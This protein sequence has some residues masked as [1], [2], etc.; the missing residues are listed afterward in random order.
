[1]SVNVLGG[2]IASPQATGIRLRVAVSGCSVYHVYRVNSRRLH[3]IWT[4]ES[5][6]TDNGGGDSN[7]DD[8]RLL[9]DDEQGAVIKEPNITCYYPNITCSVAMNGEGYSPCDSVING[10]FPLVVLLGSRVDP[11]HDNIEDQNRIMAGQYWF[12]ISCRSSPTSLL[13]GR[14]RTCLFVEYTTE[15]RVTELVKYYRE[16]TFHWNA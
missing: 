13:C 6:G 1:M 4:I 3:R 8:R 5:S 16:L 9:T 11:Q 15:C 10:F 2:G 14:K 12:H 7:V